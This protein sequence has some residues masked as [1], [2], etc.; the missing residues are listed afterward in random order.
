[1]IKFVNYK[2]MIELILIKNKLI[3]SNVIFDKYQK[4]IIKI[5]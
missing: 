1:M 3:K 5:Y 4:Y 2:L